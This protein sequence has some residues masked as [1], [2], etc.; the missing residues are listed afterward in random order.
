MNRCSTTSRYRTVRFGLRACLWALLLVTASSA[1]AQVYKFTDEN[2]IINYTNVKPSSSKYKLKV[3]G[4]YGTCKRKVNWHT[5]A[6][7]T[8]SYQQ[9][10]ADLA[11]EYELDEALLRALIH[12][13]SGFNPR[14]TSPKGAQGLMQLMPGTQRDLGVS[15]AYTAE[16]NLRGGSRYLAQM[17]NLFED[18]T[19]YALAAYNAGPNAVRNYD[20]VP[21]YTET[22]EY[23]RRIKILHARYRTELNKQN[24]G[25]A[26]I[27]TAASSR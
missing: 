2:G 26:A 5:V 17:L 27:T 4:C 22:R 25:S 12:A 11:V 19:D 21:P 10:V 8:D 23:I 15:N 24:P 1:M 6:L 14:A 9:L 3:I 7:N 20:G 16:E 18:K 13:E